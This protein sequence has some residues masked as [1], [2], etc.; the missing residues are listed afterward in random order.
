MPN[1]AGH[2]AHRAISSVYEVAYMRAITAAKP[3]TSATITVNFVKMRRSLAV[4]RV[5]FDFCF[6]LSAD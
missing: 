5:S 1:S 4:S 3:H 6:R 2:N